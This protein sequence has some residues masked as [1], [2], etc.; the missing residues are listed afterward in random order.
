MQRV[1]VTSRR[2]PK[3]FTLQSW[4]KQCGGREM[5]GAE[6]VEFMLSGFHIILGRLSSDLLETVRDKAGLGIKRLEEVF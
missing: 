4:R 2:D 1:Q 3:G 5:Q 6:N